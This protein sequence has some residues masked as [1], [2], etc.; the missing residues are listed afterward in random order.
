VRGILVGE[1]QHA[2]MRLN[3][4]EVEGRH[5]VEQRL[6]LAKPNIR[7]RAIAQ[8]ETKGLGGRLGAVLFRN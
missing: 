1:F 2:E 6:A 8:A 3:H 4:I 5:P 7:W